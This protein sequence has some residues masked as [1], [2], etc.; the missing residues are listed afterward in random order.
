[1]FQNLS[2]L[3]TKNLNSRRIFE[4]AMEYVMEEEM[5]YIEKCCLNVMGASVDQ[6]SPS[7]QLSIFKN[8]QTCRHL[9]DLLHNSYK[10][11]RHEIYRLVLGILHKTVAQCPEVFVE[12]GGVWILIGHLKKFNYYDSLCM[13]R[14]LV[15]SKQQKIV[16]EMG[17]TDN[18]QRL[19]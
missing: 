7:D 10:Q 13:L 1:M 4:T 17:K 8:R 5:G 9:L 2:F 15:T 19:V 14:M 6:M 11:N 18:V 3:M 12:M 16:M